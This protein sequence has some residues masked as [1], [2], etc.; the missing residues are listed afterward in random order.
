MNL[1]VHQQRLLVGK[2]ES[3]RFPASQCGASDFGAKTGIGD[4]LCLNLGFRYV[5]KP[6][7]KQ[8]ILTNLNQ[9]GGATFHLI[10]SQE[11]SQLCNR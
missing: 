10:L 11:G 8:R 2:A 6:P 1:Q 3:D 5:T 4:R 7:L 9:Y